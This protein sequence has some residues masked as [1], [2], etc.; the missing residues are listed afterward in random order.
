MKEREDVR[1][2]FMEDV[3][4]HQGI[5]H[6]IA[7]LYFDDP[8]EREDV[9]QDVLLNAWRSYDS[10]AGASAFSTWLYK[11]ALNTALLKLRASRAARRKSE[12]LQKADAPIAN[13]DA[14]D[15]AVLSL[16]SAMRTLNDLEKSIILLHLDG[17]SYRETAE[18]TG[19]T[20]GHIGVKLNRI[21]Q[22]LKTRLAPQEESDGD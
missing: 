22:K 14:R 20:E 8:T 15:D 11:V 13:V 17:K 18:I 5:I 10:F 4:R 1:N 21:K 6:K 9:F 19:L 16:R 3:F 2:R 12:G 7:R